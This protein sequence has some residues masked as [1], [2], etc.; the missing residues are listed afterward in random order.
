VS[1]APRPPVTST[2]SQELEVPS[3]RT[4]STE[5][6]IS[7]TPAQRLTMPRSPTPSAN[8]SSSETTTTDNSGIT[9]A[10]DVYR[11]E[12][13]LRSRHRQGEPQREYLVRWEGYSPTNDSWVTKDDIAPGLVRDYEA[14]PRVRAA[15][16]RWRG[17]RSF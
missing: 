13:I 6:D 5:E 12:K 1:T 16:S 15:M 17:R 7:E 14:Q 3:A 4:E 10:S 2:T 9:E 11:V 8:S